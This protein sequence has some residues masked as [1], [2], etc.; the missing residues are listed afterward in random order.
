MLN[1]ERTERPTISEIRS[2]LKKVEAPIPFSEPLK[3]QVTGDANCQKYEDYFFGGLWC[4]KPLILFY[5]DSLNPIGFEM[6]PT[7][8]QL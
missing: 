8:S 5:F 4:S 2:K 7:L 6:R 1:K 3:S